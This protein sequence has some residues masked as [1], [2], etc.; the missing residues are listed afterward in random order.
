MRHR[1]VGR[2]DASTSFAIIDRPTA[3]IDVGNGYTLPL[4]YYRT[5][6]GYLAA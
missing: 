2:H 6:T 5:L 1:T 3:L 4:A